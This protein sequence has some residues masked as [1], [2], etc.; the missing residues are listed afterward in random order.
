MCFAGNGN[1]TLTGKYKADTFSY[2]E[3]KLN[4]CQNDCASD[5]YIDS[6]LSNQ[7]LQLAYIDSFVDSSTDSNN[8]IKRYVDD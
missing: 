7:T 4:R 2:I 8:V 6:W 5:D 3:I 1:L